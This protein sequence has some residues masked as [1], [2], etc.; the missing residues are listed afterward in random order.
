MD[1]H[2]NQWAESGS[3]IW[4][5]YAT[6]YTK[7]GQTRTVE[8][9][10]P[11]PVGASAETRERLIREAEVGMSQLTSHIEQRGTQRA[12]NSSTTQSA[13][14]Q[15]QNAQ[16]T[17]RLAPQPASNTRPTPLPRQT[18]R[19]AAVSAPQTSPQPSDSQENESEH[20]GAGH[21]NAAPRPPTRP[22]EVGN[23]MLLPQFIQ[24]IK[25]NMDLTPKQAM[26]L[27]NV[28]SLSTGINLRDAVEQLKQRLGQEIPITNGA[29]KPNSSDASFIRESTFS[30]PEAE[31]S[32][33]TGSLPRVNRDATPVI[34][35]RARQPTP[36]F[37]EEI[38]PD[39]SNEDEETF[40]DLE[41]LEL[42]N[43][44]SPMIL[45]RARNK[46]SE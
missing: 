40:D 8:M 32:G 37:D 42:P 14:S 1:D 41:D 10:V 25:E 20:E 23:N 22:G 46:L 19:P 24:Y 4:L 36:T 33:N 11:I 39:E 45:E 5:R 2:M 12:Q 29:R 3:Y 34:E 21:Q 26:E 16:G 31:R 30:N 38:G 6:Q 13:P 43:E 15:P 7:D 28:R 9:S 44:L 27:L 35:M 18:V 17:Q